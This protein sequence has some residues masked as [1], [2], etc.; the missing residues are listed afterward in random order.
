M[1]TFD[2]LIET[3][4]LIRVTVPLGRDQ[5]HERKIY[6]LPDCLDWMRNEVPKM[7]TGRISSAFSPQEQLIERL[8]Q[9][10]SGDPMIYGPMFRDIEHPKD[11]DGIWELKTADLRIFGWMYRPKEFIAVRGGYT[12]DY[13]EP[14][15]IKSYADDKR[16]VARA[17]GLLPLDG[18]KYVSGDFNDL[19]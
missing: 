14:T 10:M 15:K 2:T 7:K 9:W 12:D 8:R 11:L 19:V 6:A 16:E 3:K 1:A 18:D 4:V 17:R 5:F 13:K